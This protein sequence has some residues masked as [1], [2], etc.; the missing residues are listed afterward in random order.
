MERSKCE[1]QRIGMV[2]IGVKKELR[3]SWSSWR[4]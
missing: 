3:R 4:G 1:V 2:C